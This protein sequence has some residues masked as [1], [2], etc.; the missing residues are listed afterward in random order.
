M[1]STHFHQI[2]L[3]TLLVLVSDSRIENKEYQVSLFTDTL[4]LDLF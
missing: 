1:Q 2:M 4:D 3:T